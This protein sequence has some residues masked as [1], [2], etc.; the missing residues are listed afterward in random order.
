MPGTRRTRKG[1]TGVGKNSQAPLGE[2]WDK[3]S[4]PDENDGRANLQAGDKGR[5]PGGRWSKAYYETG[6]KVITWDNVR[7]V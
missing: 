7:D 6:A 5:E 2:Q 4:G 3:K 1:Q